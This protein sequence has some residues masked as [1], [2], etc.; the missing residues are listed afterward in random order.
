MGQ[1]QNHRLTQLSPQRLQML[2]VFTWGIALPFRSFH[3]QN[4]VPPKEM[5]G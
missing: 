4:K 3:C 1:H 5:R 2:L